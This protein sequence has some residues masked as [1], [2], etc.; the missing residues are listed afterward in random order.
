[1]HH[2]IMQAHDGPHLRDLLEEPQA[3]GVT[4]VVFPAQEYKSERAGD[5]RGHNSRS[6]LYETARLWPRGS[7][8]GFAERFLKDRSRRC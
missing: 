5:V 4:R 7:D 1:M 2:V 3:Y 8:G 6:G